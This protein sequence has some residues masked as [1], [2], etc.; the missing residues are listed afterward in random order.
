M[1]RKLTDFNK[2]LAELTELV[3]HIEQGDLTLEQALKEFER[4]VK[5]T[6]DCQLAIQN[7]EQKISILMDETKLQP[8]D[9]DL[10]N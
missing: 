2:N 1:A 7:A 6:K 5:L 4:G 10:Q 9:D 8:F 3:N